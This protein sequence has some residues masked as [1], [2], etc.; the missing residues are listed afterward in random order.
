M[1]KKI[2]LILLGSI[3]GLLIFGI[4]MIASVSASISLQKYGNSYHY[5]LHQ[6]ISIMIGLFL[7]FLAFKIDLGLIKKWASFLLLITLVLMFLVFIPGLGVSAGGAARW[8]NLG[9][10][11]FQP[12]EL[13]KLTF[14]LYLANWLDT[15]ILQKNKISQPKEKGFS[16]TFY[17]FLIVVAIIGIILFLQPDMSTFIII[18]LTALILYFIAQT[19]LLHIIALLVVGGSSLGLLAILA[20]YRMKRISVFL[21]PET[22]PM[23]IGYQI[24]QALMA[25]GSG[26]I[27]GL[28]LGM[29]SQSIFLPASMTDSIFAV[30]AEE[31][32]FLGCLILIILFLIFFWRSFIIGKRCRDNF[33]KLTVFGIASWILI[34][35]LI[36]ISSMVGLFPLAGIPLPFFSYGGSA[37][38]IELIGAGILLNIAKSTKQS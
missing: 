18:V 35:T 5:F 15:K 33:Q 28:G 24:K 9:F 7:G 25:I 23:G 17:A 22:D 34:Q 20:P 13:L 11:S 38:V 21:D 16:Q 8:L 31:T 27:F 6:A 3:F 2:D 36:N 29:S 19:P 1:A 12:S 30:T 14:V 37:M 10:T 32:G 26:G 4:L